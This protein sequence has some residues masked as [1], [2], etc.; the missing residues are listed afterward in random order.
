MNWNSFPDLPEL[1][2]PPYWAT[3]FISEKSDDLR[4]YS[5]ID[6]KTLEAAKNTEGYLGYASMGEGKNGIFISYWDSL[7]AID[8]WRNNSIHL[9]AKERG[10]STWYNQ[11]VT[12]IVEIKSHSIK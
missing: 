10:K 9:S 1:P 7:E 12:Q 6:D 5:L 11:Y 3:I 4:G 8:R 2:N